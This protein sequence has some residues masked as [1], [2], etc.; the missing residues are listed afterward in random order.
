[1]YHFFAPDQNA[2]SGSICIAGPDYNHIVRVLRLKPGDRIAVSDGRDRDSLCEIAEIGPDSVRCEVL[3]AEL[4]DSECPV[5]L[6]LFQ[7]LPKGDKMELILEKAVE[8][9]ASSVVPVEMKRC[10]VKLD[11]KK[12]A[13][14]T[15][16]WQKQAESAAKQSG[17]RIIP[18]V[19][20]VLGFKEAVKAAAAMD[21]ILVP[22]ECAE[23]ISH[24]RKVLESLKP[25]QDAAIFI[26]PEGGFEP[27]EIEALKAENA[28][29]I[30]LGPR[31]LRTETAG[32]ATL[33]MCTLLLEGRN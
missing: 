6:H 33:A 23:D 20:Q 32:M 26:G 19:G 12:K 8:L 18:K 2:E 17:R 16:R 21:R 10:V 15:E 27:A 5:H 22:Y 4:A 28:D 30:T 29:V 13:A 24:T 11:E 1:M 31:I 3:P 25:G 9:G 14:R 7:G